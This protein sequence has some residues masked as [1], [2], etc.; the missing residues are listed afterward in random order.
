MQCFQRGSVRH[1]QCLEVV[2]ISISRR[3]QQQY[4][5]AGIRISWLFKKSFDCFAN[6]SHLRL[7]LGVNWLIDT[8]ECL[9][10]FLSAN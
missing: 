2:H 4:V 6:Y 9:L 3:Q 5:S 7:F 10:I 1:T 8:L